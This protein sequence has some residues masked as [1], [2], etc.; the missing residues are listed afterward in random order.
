MINLNN[1]TESNQISEKINFKITQEPYL[2]KNFS[3]NWPAQKKWNFNF[4]KNLNK[5]LTINTVVGNAASGETKIINTTLGDYIEKINNNNCDS[6]LTTFHLFKK[7]PFLKNDIDFKTIKK[8]TILQHYLAWI[9]PKSSITGFHVDWSENLNVQIVGKKDFYLVSPKFNNMMYISK[10]FERISITSEV[11]LMNYDEL[12][13]PN[14]KNVEII[15]FT[16]MPGDAIYIPRGWW[17]YVE[18]LESSISVSCHYWSL[19][20]FLRDIP[21]EISKVWL[22]DIGIYKKN[23]CACHVLKNNCRVK[24]G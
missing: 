4:I 24:R 6:Y 11:D 2:I 7:F 22:H 20:N 12:K 3:K 16:L 18:T 10:K 5:N 19:K 21:I 23:N 15:K 9:G 1:I 14:F 8:N 13:F 17:H